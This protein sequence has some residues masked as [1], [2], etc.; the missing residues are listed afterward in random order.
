M[1]EHNNSSR[2][3]DLSCAYD[4]W[5]PLIRLYFRSVARKAIDFLEIKD[6][7]VLLDFGCGNQRLRGFLE[8]KNSRAR[9]IGY[10]V[11]SK[12]SDVTDYKQVKANKVVCAHVLEHLTKDQLE[13]LIEYL[14]RSKVESFVVALPTENWVS[15]LGAFLSRRNIAHEGHVMTYKDVHRILRNKLRLVRKANIFTMTVV[16]E[17]RIIS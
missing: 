2:A 13:E 4:H 16:T 11:V 12:Y 3:H 9:Y 14:V 6:S 8:K 5:I 7:D 17:W 15:K 1:E 10:D